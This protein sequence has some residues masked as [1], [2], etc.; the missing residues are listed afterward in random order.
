VETSLFD[1]LLP[2]EL[3]AQQPIEPRDAARMLVSENANVA[4]RCVAD[5][6]DYCRPGDLIVV[7]ETRVFPARLLG[8]KD[9]GGAR[10]V[11]LIHAL[12]EPAAGGGE[13]WTAYI[14]GRVAVG[15]GITIADLTLRVSRCDEDGTRV[16]DFP[17]GTDV[18]VFAQ[19]HGKIPLPPYIKRDE[20]PS[21]RDRY[22]S[23]FATRPGSVAAPTAS[24]HFTPAVVKKL[25]S[26]G[27]AF[28]RVDLSIGPGTFKPVACERVEDHQIHREFCRCPA[29]TVAAINACRA[30]AGRVIAIGTT[31]VRTLETA[32]AQ[33]GGLAPYSG[34]TSLFLHPPQRFR[35]VDA[36]MTNFHL[37][38]SS[39]LMLVSCLTGIEPLK[40]LYRE[41]IDKAY[42]FYSYGDA[43]LLI[44][45]ASG[46]S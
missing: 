23:M 7:N 43:M 16:V 42:R 44:P 18:M 1:Y 41:A 40:A 13:R 33:P 17:A 2:P 3:I 22:Q 32:A 46:R 29:E 24:L 8:N 14:R 28:A 26:R 31:V 37:P 25:E 38:R 30:R 9:T 5:L 19:R 12:A 20:Q 39:L 34:W 21:D 45:V 35:I 10:E 27:V 15:N 6:P 11:L 4:H 36:L